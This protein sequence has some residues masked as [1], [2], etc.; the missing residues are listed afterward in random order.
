MPDHSDLKTRLLAIIRSDIH[1][2]IVFD[3]L[4]AVPVGSRGWLVTEDGDPALSSGS[5]L[6]RIH[7]G[8]VCDDR[9]YTRITPD[10]N[11]R[12][13]STSGPA[14]DERLAELIAAV[15]VPDGAV[16][17]SFEATKERESDW[18]LGYSV[19]YIAL[20]QAS[21]VAHSLDDEDLIGLGET[22]RSAGSLGESG[23]YDGLEKAIATFAEE[24]MH[25]RNISEPTARMEMDEPDPWGER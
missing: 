9:E 25:R 21:V 16:L 13:N 1:R 14:N 12:F 18:E 3:R 7:S 4:D 20:T 11:W 15:L 10:P 2:V 8:W 24:A 6:V 22:M 5:H 19:E 17:V 23:A